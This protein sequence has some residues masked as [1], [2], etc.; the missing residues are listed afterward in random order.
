MYKVFDVLED[1]Q[2]SIW[3]SNVSH[4]YAFFKCDQDRNSL[5]YLDQI[6]ERFMRELSSAYSLLLHSMN[7]PESIW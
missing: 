1:V 4:T 5:Q 6:I 7:L 3:G 2:L